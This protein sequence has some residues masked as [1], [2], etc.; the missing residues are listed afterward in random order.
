MVWGVELIVVVQT[1]V[2]RSVAVVAYVLIYGADPAMQTVIK[3]ALFGRDLVERVEL[4]PLPRLI[5]VAAVSLRS[6]LM[7]AHIRRR[8]LN[9]SLLV[10]R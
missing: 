10:I 1:N 3:V 2:S 6:V 9:M 4:R 5:N 7:V 8:T